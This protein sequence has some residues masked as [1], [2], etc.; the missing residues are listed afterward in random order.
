MSPND[1][2]L[3]RASRPRGEVPTQEELE[4]G[5]L[6]MKALTHMETVARAWH[7]AFLKQVWPL[8]V[9]RQKWATLH[10]GVKV[11]DVG[12]IV[13]TSKYG[14]ATWQACRVLAL[15]PDRKGVVRL[16][17]IGVRCYYHRIQGPCGLCAGRR[18]CGCLGFRGTT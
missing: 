13:H 14:K 18:S 1:I 10:P 2:I 6:P 5:D 15:L 9:P 17:T 12:F 3:G 4:K 16:V 11:G 7:G 8:L